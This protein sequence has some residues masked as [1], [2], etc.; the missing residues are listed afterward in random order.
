VL[1]KIHEFHEQIEDEDFHIKFDE[2]EDLGEFD[3]FTSK[4]PCSIRV[5]DLQVS[6]VP[7][8]SST[9][10]KQDAPLKEKG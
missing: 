8:S 7:W 5:R 10:R 2:F 3:L 4:E 1:I 9:S 6:V